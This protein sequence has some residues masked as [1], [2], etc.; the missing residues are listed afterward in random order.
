MTISINQNEAHQII[1]HNFG[2]I[3]KEIRE[4]FFERYVTSRKQGG[5][6][7]GT[8]S[9][10]LIAKTHGGDIT[11]TSSED[12]GTQLIITLPKNK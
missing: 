12:K 7:V 8:Y 2:V 3:P 9:A 5:T 6:G 4:R 11:F 10:L 1:I